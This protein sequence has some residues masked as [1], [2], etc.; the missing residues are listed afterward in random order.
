[1]PWPEKLMEE[2]ALLT[3]DRQQIF[4]IIESPPPPPRG[5]DFEVA[6]EEEFAPNKLRA[7]IERL[8]MGLV[9]WSLSYLCLVSV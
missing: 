3:S 9:S 2:P 8:Y 7:Q 5:L 1:M 4:H 6:S